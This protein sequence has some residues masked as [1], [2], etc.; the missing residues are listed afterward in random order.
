MDSDIDAMALRSVMD[1]VLEAL[2]MP[3]GESL[4]DARRMV[5][6]IMKENPHTRVI[7]ANIVVNFCNE[8]NEEEEEKD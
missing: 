3:K 6:E 4:K 1:R 8:K 2:H 7:V 5:K